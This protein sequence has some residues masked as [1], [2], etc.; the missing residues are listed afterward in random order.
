M[1]NGISPI[2]LNFQDLEN[3]LFK[4]IVIILTAQQLKTV[5]IGLYGRPYVRSPLPLQHAYDA[6]V[7]TVL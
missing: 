4:V 3:E 6:A 1:H 2:T 7:E 5:C